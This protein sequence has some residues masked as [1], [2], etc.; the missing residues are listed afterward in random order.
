MADDLASPVAISRLIHQVERALPTGIT[1]RGYR[2]EVSQERT[3]AFHPDVLSYGAFDAPEIAYLGGASRSIIRTLAKN[4]DALRPTDADRQRWTFDQVVTVRLLQSF[5]ARGANFKRDPQVL[6]SRLR[7]VAARSEETQVAIDANG[8]IYIQNNGHFRTL[9]GQ[10]AL[11]TVLSVDDAFRPFALGNSQVPDL[12]RPGQRTSVDPRVIGGT[13]CVRDRRIAV[14]AI[15]DVHRVR[16]DS[17]VRSAFPELTA[18]ELQDA[19]KV[20]ATI[21]HQSAS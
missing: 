16:G 9:R 8:E 13:P 12:L 6:L 10:E 19:I 5:K 7:E 11:A 18:Q 21:E 20:G 17:V 4:Y 2:E 3:P 14:R 15:Y 1:L